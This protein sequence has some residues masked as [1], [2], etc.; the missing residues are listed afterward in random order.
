MFNP[1]QDLDKTRQQFYELNANNNMPTMIR[2]ASYSL[3]G[4]M[5]VVYSQIF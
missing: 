4:I 1:L 3:A 2:L 5:C